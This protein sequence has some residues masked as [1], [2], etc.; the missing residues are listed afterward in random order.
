MDDPDPAP[1]PAPDPNKCKKPD[2]TGYVIVDYR[3]GNYVCDK[4]GLTLRD[5]VYENPPHFPKK[6][7]DLTPFQ[8][9]QL[10]FRTKQFAEKKKLEQANVHMRY[11]HSL[12]VPNSC[13]NYTRGSAQ[14]R[15]GEYW[16]KVMVD[17]NKELDTHLSQQRPQRQE[18]KQFFE[19][20]K[21]ELLSAIDTALVSMN[22]H[23][24]IA[25]AFFAAH[26]AQMF[27]NSV[28]IP[29]LHTVPPLE[30]SLQISE[31]A[32]G[33]TCQVWDATSA[34]AISGADA[35]V[36]AG[37][38]DD[39]TTGAGVGVDA[40]AGAGAG[41]GTG[42]GTGAGAGAGAGTGADWDY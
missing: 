13:N 10:S 36:D 19:K 18:G 2:C 39:V 35:C 29:E 24:A 27:A 23:Y 37:T 31:N 7:R 17:Y 1:D 42:A 5:P 20:V 21:I 8:A 15:M 40:G 9:A 41:A 26:A 22:N 33:S 3:E 38:H 25:Q 32:S 4:C 12:R 30:N 11:I 16:E 6:S 14:F 34:V 28:T